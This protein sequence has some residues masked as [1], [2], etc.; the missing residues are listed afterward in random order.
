[1][2]STRN[3]ATEFLKTRSQELGFLDCGIAKADYLEEEASKLEQW[4]HAGNHGSM[5][6]LERN[7]DLRLD[8]RKLVPGAKS[9]VVLLFNYFPEETIPETDNYKIARYAYGRDYHKVLKKKLK[10]LMNEFREEFGEVDGRCFVDSAPV[11]ERVW[12]KKAGLGWAGKNTLLLSQK[13]GSYFFLAEMFMDMELE[14]DHPTTDHC[15]SC[16]ACIDA[17]PTDALSPYRLDS[18]RCISYLTIELKE[19]IPTEYDGKMED[20]IFGCDI[21]QEVCPWNRFSKSHNEPSF[22]PKEP[23]KSLRKP[24]WEEI[25]EEI[26]AEIFAGSAVKR[27]GFDGFKRN[28]RAAGANPAP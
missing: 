10:Q 8:A 21:C 24:D 6:Y 1:M 2:H 20:W 27:T 17:C 4:L 22:E 12:A 18:N 7:F 9:V 28:I 25:T 16:T 15:G 19:A 13:K 3:R 23:L 11:M 5:S 26:F 14:Y